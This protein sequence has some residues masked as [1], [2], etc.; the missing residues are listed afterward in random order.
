MQAAHQ[1][2]AYK[3]NNFSGDGE[4][5]MQFT[6]LKDSNGVD[7]YEGDIV[8]MHQFL[9]DGNEVEQI[10][11]GVIIWGEYGW[12]LSQISGPFVNEYMGFE[13]G[14]GESYLIY[15]YGLHEESFVVLG[16]IHEGL[17]ELA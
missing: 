11:K 6:G 8:S 16:N 10:T 2:N 1:L 7:I 17:K 9:F 13:D 15:F 14:E 3:D 12:R 5:M 4:I